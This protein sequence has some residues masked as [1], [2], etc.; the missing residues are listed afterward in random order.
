MDG[1]VRLSRRSVSCD[2]LGSLRQIARAERARLA[3]Q[4]KRNK[5]YFNHLNNLGIDTSDRQLIDA[6]CSTLATEEITTGITT[7]SQFEDIPVI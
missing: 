1:S 2:Y 7:V 6:I 4:T 5:R 3:Q